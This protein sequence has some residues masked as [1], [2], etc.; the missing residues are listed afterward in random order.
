MVNTPTFCFE[1]NN[2]FERLGELILHIAQE[3]AQDATFGSI[4]LNKILWFSDFM[5]YGKFKTPITG[6]AYFKLPNGPAPRHLVGVRD[7]LVNNRDA[8]ISRES[9]VL[10]HERIRLVPLRDPDLSMFNGSQ[11]ALVNSVIKLLWDKSAEEISEL[12]HGKAW[13]VAGD[14]EDI[15]YEA[16]FLSNK[17]PTSE[18]VLRTRE[19]A[20]EFGWA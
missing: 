17:K 11:I 1:N 19:L 12:S 14:K 6:V 18:D 4:K 16:I 15:P 9:T 13:T 7:R 10:G 5:A 20:Q 2:Q 3:C 8:A